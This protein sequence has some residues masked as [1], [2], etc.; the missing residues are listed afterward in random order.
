[1]PVKAASEKAV[2]KR[3]MPFSIPIYAL[4]IALATLPAVLGSLFAIPPL[5]GAAITLAAGLVAGFFLARG[6]KSRL[7]EV[8]FRYEREVRPGINRSMDDARE[9]LALGDTASVLATD[10]AGDVWKISDGITR[11]VNGIL[12]EMTGLSE[13]IFKSA[14]SVTEIL[15]TIESLTGHV[16]SQGS[17][18]T[19]VAGSVRMMDK[20]LAEISSVTAERSRSADGLME[21]V[22]EGRNILSE[23]NG[24]IRGISGDVEGMMDIIGVIDGIASQTNML[25][26]NAAI[27]AAH[28]GDAGRGFSVVAEEIRKLAESAAENARAI[29]AS[30][31]GVNAGMAQVLKSGEASEASF[32]DVAT[33]VSLFVEAFRRIAD[34]AAE[35]ATGSGEILLSTEM[36]DSMSGKITSGSREISASAREISGSM[37]EIKNSYGKIN[38][39]VGV[40]DSRAREITKAQDDLL[41]IL[42]WSAGSGRRVGA[43]IEPW[44]SADRSGS[45]PAGRLPLQIGD[46]MVRLL[47]RMENIGAAIRAMIFK[48]G[49]VLIDREASSDYRAS[50]VG[51]WLLGEGREAFGEKGEY[52]ILV[53]EYEAFHERIRETAR[54]IE[55]GNFNES[56]ASF[57]RVRNSYNNLIVGFIDLISKIRDRRD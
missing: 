1:M 15:A 2:T 24:K 57:R 7:A 16:V 47:R 3:A 27:E 14:S 18:I 34:K 44:E 38:T 51:K 50:G 56:F 32:S 11:D 23:S 28:A 39:D 49:D 41:K 26:M 40:I 25:A 20:S 4:V 33:Q 19:Q 30:L 53:A 54:I 12:E 48:D 55:T 10:Y 5:F 36:L 46:I 35:A 6:V 21:T 8:T 29:A 13:L 43:I 31:N 22:G 9:M 52:R 42:E 17:A 37:E 45:F